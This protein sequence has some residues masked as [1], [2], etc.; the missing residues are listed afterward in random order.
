MRAVQE[1]DGLGEADEVERTDT[2]ALFELCILEKEMITIRSNIG[3]R[4]VKTNSVIF[5][6][7]KISLRQQVNRQC[8]G[9][10]YDEQQRVGNC[11]GNLK[12]FGP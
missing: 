1:Y 6:F 5:S 12:D 10:Q 9:I 3:Q 2:I 11:L 8:A 7:L 4:K